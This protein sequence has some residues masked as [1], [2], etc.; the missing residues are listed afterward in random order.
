MMRRRNSSCSCVRWRNSTPRCRPASATIYCDFEDPKG[1]REAVRRFRAFSTSPGRTIR[2]AP[3]RIFKTGE[4]WILKQVRSSE[5]D[6][7]LVRNYDHLRFFA[8]E[9]RL[10]GDFSLN[11][12]NPLTARV[13]H[14]TRTGWS[15]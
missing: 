5:A 3:P 8:G 4:D 14:G 6:G 9:R 15:G 2:V 11:V 12:A 10:V 1:Y 13:F 7:Y